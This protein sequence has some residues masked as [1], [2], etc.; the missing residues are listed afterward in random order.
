ML[1]EP[2]P[3]SG[4]F[5]FSHQLLSVLN[6]SVSTSASQTVLPPP[7]KMHTT[8]SLSSL[9]C[10]LFPELLISRNVSYMCIFHKVSMRDNSL[11][12]YFCIEYFHFRTVPL[13][14]RIK[15]TQ[16]RHLGHQIKGPPRVSIS[17]NSVPWVPHLPHP[18]AGPKGPE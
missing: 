1:K 5:S 9:P 18:S 2:F 17:L 6:P 13:R 11:F 10:F 4:I 12:R 8:C 14:A 15:M 7:Q 16:E 3:S